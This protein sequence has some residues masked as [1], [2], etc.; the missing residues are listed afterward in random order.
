MRRPHIVPLP[1][2]VVEALREIQDVTGRNALKFTGGNDAA[3]PISKA[4][5]NQVLK[6]IGYHSKKTVQGVS[7]H[8]EYH[9]HQQVYNTAW[10]KLQLAQVDKNTIRGAYNH[11]Q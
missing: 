2:Q 11:T 3:K 9:L 6:R 4:S 8:N 10:I 5:I 7:T 1:T